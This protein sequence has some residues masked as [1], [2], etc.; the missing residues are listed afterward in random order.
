MATVFLFFAVY[1]KLSI[2][3]GVILIIFCCY[4]FQFH[5][6][7]Y[8][9]VSNINQAKYSLVQARESIANDDKVYQELLMLKRTA[10]WKALYVCFVICIIL[11]YASRFTEEI[12]G[13]HLNVIRYIGL[14]LG[15]YHG[16][17]S[18]P[19]GFFYDTLGYLMLFIFLLIEKK[20][21]QWS[22]NRMGLNE[23]APSDTQEKNE[24]FYNPIKEF[25]V[26]AQKTE[27]KKEDV[28]EKGQEKS[29]IK[30]IFLTVSLEYYNARYLIDNE[31][32]SYYYKHLTLSS[33]K[34]LLEE[35]ILFF[36]LVSCVW[37]HNVFM[38][39]YIGFVVVLVIHGTSLKITIRLH[40]YFLC[41]F[42]LQY[43]I[44]LITISDSIAPQ[45]LYY[46]FI[47][48]D[49]QSFFE[50]FGFNAVCPLYK[51]VDL[52]ENWAQF[53]SIGK[54]SNAL[55]FLAS[56]I[57]I[58]LLFSI[59]FQHFC[60][61]ALE[62]DMDLIHS[63]EAEDLNLN[64]SNKGIFEKLREN[65]RSK[66]KSLLERFCNAMEQFLFLYLHIFFLFIIFVL[67]AQSQGL[68]S[69]GYLGFCLFFL[70]RNVQ[71]AKN[72]REWKYP[73]WLRLF[74]QP[75]L[76]TDLF[77]QFIIQM[78][79]GE[80]QGPFW[81][82]FSLIQPI[83]SN[84][85][86]FTKLIML[87]I[88]SLQVKVFKSSEF[89]RFMET[90]NEEQRKT[91]FI[92]GWCC[93]FLYNNR[94]VTKYEKYDRMKQ[95]HNEK[96]DN[97]REQIDRWNEKLEVSNPS[98]NPLQ[99][100]R[101]TTF[102]R[103]TSSAF[104]SVAGLKTELGDASERI[105]KIDLLLDD[106]DKLGKDYIRNMG[107][108]FGRLYIW[109]HTFI[110]HVLFK[111]GEKLAKLLKNT[112]KGAYCIKSKLEK[113]ITA[114][115]VLKLQIEKTKLEQTLKLAQSSDQFEELHTKQQRM[116]KSI[117]EFV[118]FKNIL[119]NYWYCIYKIL[120]SSTEFYCYLFMILAH[121]FNGSLLSL[122]YLLSIFGYG[123][124]EH[125]RPKSLYWNIMLIYTICVL[126]FKCI[127]QLDAI[128]YYFI[129]RDEMINWFGNSSWRI[130]ISLY[131][132]TA[133]FDFFM[134]ILFECLIIMGILIHENVLIFLGVYDRREVEIED[135][136]EAV[137]R[138]CNPNFDPENDLSPDN[139][140][141]E[142][143]Q[144]INI[145]AVNEQS[146]EAPLPIKE[147]EDAPLKLN[148]RDMHHTEENMTLKQYVFESSY[149]KSL[150][151]DSKVI[152]HIVIILD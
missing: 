146:K 41:L 7:V 94:R 127:I 8:N 151:P 133:T 26:E 141:D 96:L 104:A 66:I 6:S 140:E 149:S 126:V 131:N 33:I 109:L 63:K 62:Q 138:L 67:S 2:S 98:K 147:E 70:S 17:I 59:Y 80:K 53:L 21:T 43:C 95:D 29:I 18:H 39:L 114:N 11:S 55:K 111:K 139:S 135:M 152:L 20:A 54:A 75:Y 105:K 91:T 71:F 112:A 79:L 74:L 99:I 47:D 32:K 101:L 10:Y 87:T 136:A 22:F 13:A 121:L 123:L 64:K 130:G 115:E 116:E 88:M 28:K 37:K 97:I 103:S 25:T 46:P 9:N 85:T 102:K 5:S 45:S 128:S 84:T 14:V 108:T 19:V 122:V 120:L 100:R 68:Y 110:N 81:K 1:W 69:V 48:S 134:Y 51:N 72:Y 143:D 78:P 113:L 61:L 119:K 89:S 65:A 90:Y 86:I 129:S 31:L 40:K 15:C 148:N 82:I 38:L 42:A 4:Y 83:E 76:F 145:E 3:T 30:S 142:E 92:K 34:S 50:L 24:L 23:Q 44:A 73:L 49:C 36:V 137:D 93:T 16:E 107:S 150:F 60:H 58:L 125:C 12:I 118:G 124:V 132:S 117:E 144:I 27:D 52:W 56:D 106:K 57:V 77:S 35:I